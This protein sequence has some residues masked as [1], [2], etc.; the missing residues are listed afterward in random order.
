M[1]LVLEIFDQN[2]IS[3]VN[4]FIILVFFYYNILSYRKPYILSLSQKLEKMMLKV[5]IMTQ[6]LCMLIVDQQ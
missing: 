2:V 5:I 3:R 6:A 1:V 4:I